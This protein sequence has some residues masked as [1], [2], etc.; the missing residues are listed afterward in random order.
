MNKAFWVTLGIIIALAGAILFLH[1]SSGTDLVWK[2]TDEGTSFFPLVVIAAF[3]D[4]INPCA[5]SILLLTIA[6]LLSMGKLRSH[7]LK[8]GGMYVF[9]IFTAYI[10][11]GLGITQALHL[12]NAPNFMGKLG[13]VLLIVLGLINLI[14]DLFPTFPISIGIPS[15]AHR[16]MAQLMEKTSM[17]AAFLLGGLVGLC[18][19]PCT[20]GPY[21]MILGLLHD[22]ATFSSGLGY[23]FL[24]NL[25]FVLPLA[26]ILFFASNKSLTERIDRWQRMER[27]RMK[28]WGGV[29][30]VAF[31]ILILFI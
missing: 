23:L 16:K 8:I 14:K 25:I 1:T 4:S 9:G 31:G 12:F 28:L 24:Y 22:R 6:F 29:V 19:F 30:M 20:G 13:A 15:S 18:E 2:I 11:I 3:L 10:L 21:L 7:I 17:P 27:S 26:V 5:F